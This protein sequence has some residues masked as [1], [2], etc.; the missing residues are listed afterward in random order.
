M[1][2][3]GDR[4]AFPEALK[5]LNGTM[6]NDP[7]KFREVQALFMVIYTVIFVLGIFGNTLICY[8]VCRNRTMQTVTNFFIMNLALSDILLCALCVPFTPLYTFL[9]TWVFGT[10][11]C[12]I[13]APATSVS[14]Y[15]HTV[16]LTSIAI[17]RFFVIIYPF[18]PRMKIATCFI[19]VC[20]SWLFSL[21][22]SLPYGFI[23]K[24]T[25]R[26]DN[27]TNVTDYFCE[28]E[29]PD[30]ERRLVYGS[31]TINIQFV[32]PFV[33]IAFCYTKVSMKLNEQARARPGTKNSRKEELDRER[34]RRTNRMLIAMVSIFGLSWLPLNC[35]NI[36]NDFRTD[37]GNWEY[38]NLCFFISHTLAMMSTCYNPFLY[39]WLNE[40]FRKEFKQLLPGFDTSRRRRSSADRVGGWKSER[41]CNGNET[42]A[43][44]FQSTSMVRR[45]SSIRIQLAEA[46][47]D[48]DKRN[49]VIDVENLLVSKAT[50]N[51]EKEKVELHLTTDDT[52]LL[53]SSADDN[54]SSPPNDLKGR[55]DGNVTSEKGII[56][57]GHGQLV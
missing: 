18:R 8:I 53:H 49:D 25:S 30:D 17:D 26:V 56:G 47:K 35:I 7:I 16:T 15:I 23:L 1:N 40:N 52:A 6:S 33:I 43:T 50:F 54:R 31:I 22:S 11:M 39:A 3:T 28:E 9:E 46:T 27:N 34:K 14:V 19:I 55:G 44:L 32:I 48:L 21:L 51:L 10:I 57:S 41:T 2:D 29:W 13:V 37:F 20:G 36:L 4:S 24:H 5:M 45:C 12:H 38:Y 42:E